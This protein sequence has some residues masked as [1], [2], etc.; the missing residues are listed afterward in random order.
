MDMDKDQELSKISFHKLSKNEKL[1][2][3]W[4]Y[5]KFHFLGIVFFLALV[6]AGIF[7]LKED[8]KP[9][10][11]NGYL[12]NSDWGDDKAQEL[13]ERFASAKGY[14]LEKSNAYF[15]SSVYIDIQLQDQ[16]SS[17]A[18][19]KVMSDLDMKR[20]DFYF[21]NQEIFDYFGEKEAFLNLETALSSQILEKYKNRLITTT[22]YDENGNVAETYVA[23]IDI[24]D[25]PVLIEMQ[26]NRKMYEDGKIIFSIPYNTM[27]LDTALEFLNFLYES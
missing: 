12:L 15:N 8:A 5:Y 13:L 17:V 16:M 2:Y 3:L 22:T 1:E 6:I 18:Y 14:D 19:T 27:R 21:C 20:T 10:I 11:L 4:D 26:Q 25:S 7:Y 23:G 9:D 24:S